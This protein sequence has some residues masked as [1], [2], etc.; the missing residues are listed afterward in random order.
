MT[1]VLVGGSLRRALSLG[2]IRPCVLPA[3]VVAIC[4]APLVGACAP[5]PDVI[6]TDNDNGGQ[7]PLRTGDLLDIVLAD[8]YDETGCQWREDHTPNVLVR[9]AA[10]PG[11]RCRCPSR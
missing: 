2:R 9:C 3:L 6:A 7:V 11:R 5:V 4:A 8:D 1:R 10:E